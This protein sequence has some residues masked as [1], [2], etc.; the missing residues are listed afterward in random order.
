MKHIKSYEEIKSEP[1]EGDYV[2]MYFVPSEGDRVFRNFINT[3]T[4]EIVSYNDFVT[5][6][7]ENFPIELKPNLHD[8]SAYN[9]G[10]FIRTFN[11]KFISAYSKDKKELEDILLQNKYNI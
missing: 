11:P 5:V 2:L 8:D 7:Y 6:K 1:Q 9:N 4:G 3:H 10:T